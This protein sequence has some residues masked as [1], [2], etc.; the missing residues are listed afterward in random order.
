[1]IDLSPSTLGGRWAT[2]CQP[3]DEAEA[4]IGVVAFLAGRRDKQYPTR[5]EVGPE[6]AS[7]L[8]TLGITR[9]VA[10]HNTL[11]EARRTVENYLRR[12]P[13][14]WAAGMW[15]PEIPS[16]VTYPVRRRARFKCEDGGG[17]CCG[18]FEF[19]HLHYRSV[20]CERPSDL[21]LLCRSCHLA[22][23]MRGGAFVAD[24]ETVSW[25]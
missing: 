17:N 16:F 7:D 14:Q 15:K 12:A 5:A 4:L 8:S 9:E 22:R 19:H 11:R 10:E 3:S 21:R 2:G 25:A 23:H 1:M 13:R 20:G 6:D 18:P 24:P